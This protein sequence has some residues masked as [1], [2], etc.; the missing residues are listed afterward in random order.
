MLPVNA[1]FSGLQKDGHWTGTPT[2]IIQLMEHP[3][4]TIPPMESLDGSFP[5]P[6][7]DLDQANEVS[8]NRLL[9]RRTSSPHFAYVGA[10]TLSNLACSYREHHVLIISRE[11]GRHEVAPL[12]KLLLESG[13]TVQIETT[14]MAPSLVIPDA[15][16]TLLALPSRTTSADAKPENA[17]RPDEILACIRWKADLD[18]AELLY[19][20]RSAVVWLRPSAFADGGIYRQCVAVAT[21]HAGWRVVRP[22][23]SAASDSD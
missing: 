10:S 22:Y 11:P 19:A 8:M 9:A 1:I 17:A 18:R 20:R 21:R 15:W 13:R 3:L 23:R 2:L 14:V 16:I 4:A 6:E 12:V 7:Y 5:L